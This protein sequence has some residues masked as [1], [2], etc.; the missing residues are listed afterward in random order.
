M[1]DDPPLDK[2]NKYICGEGIIEL[3]DS[4]V[5][6]ANLLEGP[7]LQ[8]CIGA[9]PKRERS[10]PRERGEAC[11]ER[12]DE[13]CDCKLH[14]SHSKDCTEQRLKTAHNTD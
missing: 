12:S 5:R 2:T 1:I 14:V 9:G 4:S 3:T 13:A 11:P 10:E 8:S 6:V 7:K